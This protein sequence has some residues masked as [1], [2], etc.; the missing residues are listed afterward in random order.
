M[1]AELVG[2]EA[3]VPTL[4]WRRP[5]RNTAPPAVPGLLRLARRALL[6]QTEEGRAEGDPVAGPL[7]GDRRPEVDDVVLQRA[8][9]GDHDAFHTIVDHYEERLRLLAFHMLRDAEQMNDAVQDTFVKAYAALPG[10]RAEAALG[11]WMHSI[12]CRVCLDYLRAARI[13]PVAERIDDGLADPAD[14]AE[15]LALCDQVAAALAGLTPEHRAVLLLVDREGYDYATVAEAL[16]VPVGTVAS[17]LS[18][19]RSA[20]R[21][22]L[23]GG[24]R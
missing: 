22:A 4:P 2:A 16:E 6:S 19:A 3:I 8:R 5:R 23:E 17:R 12:C 24:T 1:R 7:G 9:R 18:H 20:F 14:E 13:R 10:F 15:R 21:E 11:T